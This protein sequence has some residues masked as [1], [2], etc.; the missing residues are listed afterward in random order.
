[1]SSREQSIYL[2][3]DFELRAGERILLRRGRH[4]AVE[5]KVLEVMVHLAGNADRVVPKAELLDSL[6]PGVA[7]VDGVV[8]RCVS[9]A[10]RLLGDDGNGP[11][12]IATRG[13]EGYQFVAKVSAIRR[14]L[15]IEP[16]SSVPSAGAGIPALVPR[17]DL[18]GRTDELR[19]L[20]AMLADLEGARRGGVLC[21]T[22]SPGMGKSRLLDTLADDAATHGV[23]VLRSECREVSGAP[24][25]HPWIRI[26][27]D[28]AMGSDA[29]VLLDKLGSSAAD[30]GEL[31][32]A[33]V[34]SR[35]SHTSRANLSPDLQRSRF[36]ST[37]ERLLR[38]ASESRPTVI[39]ID[40]L[41]C[42]DDATLAFWR[43]LTPACSRVPLLLAC[44]YRDAEVRRHDTLA[45]I[46][47]EAFSSEIAVRCQLDG[48]GPSDTED[49]VVPLL[50]RS[51]PHR[52]ARRM[53]RR[54]QEKSEGNPFFALE[55][56]RHMLALE[57][58]IG[59]EQLETAL[60]RSSSSLSS[61]I[62]SVVALRMDA[63]RASTRQILE[64][65]ATIGRD[66]DLARLRAVCEGD[67]EAVDSAL[68]EAV[69]AE[70][71]DSRSDAPGQFRF[72][73][74]LFRDVLYNM[75][76][77]GVR[78]KRHYRIA[79]HILA[80][81]G[82]MLENYYEE[83]AHHFL[84]AAPDGYADEAISFALRAAAHA[85]QRLAFENAARSYERAITSLRLTREPSD[86]RLC[87]FMLE[88]AESWSRAGND[89]RASTAFEEAAIVARRIGDGELFARAAIG[90][91]VRFGQPVDFG[92]PSPATRNLLEEALIGLSEKPAPTRALVLACLAFSAFAESAHARA[93]ELATRSE[94]EAR[95]SG[96]PLSTCVA[97]VARH[98]VSMEPGN[99]AHAADIADELIT[100]AESSGMQEMVLVGHT[101]RTFRYL[102]DG[103][104][105]AKLDATVS[106][107]AQ[108]AAHLRQPQGQW[109]S[110]VIAATMAMMRGDWRLC[111]E[112]SH[113]AHDLALGS[114]NTNQDLAFRTQKAQVLMH[115][116]EIG[117][118][119][120]LSRETAELYPHLHTSYAAHCVVL[121]AVG[122]RNETREFAKSWH[123]KIFSESLQ[124]S[125]W[126]V[127][128][129]CLVELASILDD[130]ALAEPLYRFLEPH[131]DR[132][133]IVGQGIAYNGTVARLLGLLACVLGRF[134]IAVNEFGV[135]LARSSDFHALP[136]IARTQLNYARCLRRRCHDGDEAEARRLLSEAHE[137]SHRIGGLG[138]Q[139]EIQLVE[140]G[141][142]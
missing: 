19:V 112:E 74:I 52:T 4:V 102:E 46:D 48:L 132:N 55:L 100:V 25:F 134:D 66:F 12:I 62:R 124:P 71:V 92:V 97:L 8:H 65:A 13:R 130:A 69:A 106:A 127:E 96:D 113:A 80:T 49:L 54:I 78:R 119:L 34:H 126:L 53:A 28:L 33:L 73:H 89:Q 42:G 16:E 137:T 35:A 121:A 24:A 84:E 27:E 72:R 135:A 86:R 61:S 9:R 37:A 109:W 120:D 98:M 45:T 115:R 5:P 6:W 68:D 138:L 111:E 136:W 104:D 50:E 93:V 99:P 20:H 2:F 110:R 142:I 58:K 11:R 91:A 40:D 44:S 31:V 3:S 67:D 77:P 15:A 105:S 32:P 123:G 101:Y 140:N 76:A 60:D 63:M 39:L 81:H 129:A 21:I 83:L 17:A 128:A 47:A 108:L 117:A 10:R 133:V 38:I 118:M 70:V 79:T 114:L 51:L 75:S 7:V 64:A 26:L 14:T 59:A 122:E 57:A 82:A 36:L 85:T 103:T 125:N 41:H 95:A 23:R 139:M 94:T 1:M 29:A 131:R 22:G 90:L 56:A 107:R 18:I 30:L 88:L 141:A 116:G 43:I 87:Q